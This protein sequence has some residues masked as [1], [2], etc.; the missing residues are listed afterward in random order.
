MVETEAKAI[1]GTNTDRIWQFLPTV[2]NIH[3]AVY[4]PHLPS[5]SK[6][7]WI[8]EI[9]L[10][11]RLEHMHQY[12]FNIGKTLAAKHQFQLFNGA[13]QTG[14]EKNN[15]ELKILTESNM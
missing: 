13:F 6:L 10:C 5:A 12:I 8:C 7:T 9:M 4:K 14:H 11:R 1:W 15:Q 3:S 2:W